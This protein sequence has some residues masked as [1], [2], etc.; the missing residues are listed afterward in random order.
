MPKEISQHQWP[1]R[2]QFWLDGDESPH[3]PGVPLRVA[4]ASVQSV[5]HHL[6]LT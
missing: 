3:W 4:I 2:N 5:G 6:I 1:E